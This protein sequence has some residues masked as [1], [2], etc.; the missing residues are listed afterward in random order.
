LEKTGFNDV[1]INIF[2]LCWESDVTDTFWGRN[3]ELFIIKVGG[4]QTGH[5]AS[6]GLIQWQFAGSKGAALTAW[7]NV[8]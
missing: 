1:L 2:C 7:E 5:S 8:C 4:T 6:R 3:V